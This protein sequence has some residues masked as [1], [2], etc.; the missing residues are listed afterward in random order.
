MLSPLSWTLSRMPNE[1]LP[2]Q[3]LVSA[4][5]GGKRSAGGQKQRWNDVVSS[6]FK[7]CNLSGTW[8]E[9]AQERDFWRNIIK[10]SVEV[11]NNEAEDSEKNRNDEKKRRRQQ[12][13]IDSKNTTLSRL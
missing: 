8:R 5:V 6:E 2:K 13:L 7:Q 12:R 1:H 11:L 9:Q 10:H 4:P 3:L